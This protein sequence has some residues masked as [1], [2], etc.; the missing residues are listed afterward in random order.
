MIPDTASPTASTIIPDG[1][2]LT[3]DSLL[4]IAT[5]PKSQIELTP[6]IR[7]RV[8]ASRK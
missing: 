6:E 8:I 3:V 5:D 4:A 7:K 1:E 2:S